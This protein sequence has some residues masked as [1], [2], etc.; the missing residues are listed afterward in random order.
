MSEGVNEGKESYIYIANHGFETM[1]KK[2]IKK[3]RKKEIKKYLLHC[4]F[5]I[6]ELNIVYMQ[7]KISSL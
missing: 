6:L 2:Y 1:L 5:L 3:Y 7:D 4:K